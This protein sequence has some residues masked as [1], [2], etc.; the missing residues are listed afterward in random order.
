MSKLNFKIP[1]IAAGKVIPPKI[2]NSILQEE[3]E[4]QIRNENLRKDEERYKKDVRRSWIQ[5]WV[6]LVMSNAIAVAAL[7]VAILAY[8]K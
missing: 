6:P 8:L 2:A 1:D 7:I 5:F 4:Q 3:K